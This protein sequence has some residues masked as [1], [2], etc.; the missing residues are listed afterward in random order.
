MESEEGERIRFFVKIQIIV[1]IL[2]FEIKGIISY[3]D[4]R[5]AVIR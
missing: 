1:L 2:G 4:C 5:K 3:F